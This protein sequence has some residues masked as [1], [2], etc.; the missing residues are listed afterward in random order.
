MKQKNND[1]KTRG[2]EVWQC[3]DLKPPPLFESLLIN[4]SIV[5]KYVHQF[6]DGLKNY[7]LADRN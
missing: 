7:L 2:I 3:H 4:I 5:G 6:I 1:K